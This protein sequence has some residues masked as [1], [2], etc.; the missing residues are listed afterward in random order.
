M[1]DQD[2]MAL[3]D[4]LLQKKADLS[5]DDLESVNGGIFDM[6]SEFLQDPDVECAIVTLGIAAGQPCPICNAIVPRTGDEKAFL[7]AVTEHVTL[8]FPG[9]SPI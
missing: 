9:Q 7:A 4:K 2:R 5:L 6:L 3:R 1:K 8:H